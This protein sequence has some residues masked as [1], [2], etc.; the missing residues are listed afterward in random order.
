MSPAQLFCRTISAPT[1]IAGGSGT[2]SISCRIAG[3]AA[4]SRIAAV[5]GRII[6]AGA[7][8]R[9]GA[10]AGNVLSCAAGSRSRAITCRISAGSAARGPGRLPAT[11][12][13]RRRTQ[14]LWRSPAGRSAQLQLE[15][16]GDIAGR[17]CPGGPLCRGPGR[18]P[19]SLGPGGALCWFC[20]FSPR[21][22]SPPPQQ[23][24][25]GKT[26]AF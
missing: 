16:Q 22:P 10:A 24:E 6:A 25:A 12:R 8:S 21:G 3:A 9:T 17:P 23:L 18:P 19:I 2:R 26:D 11:C 13:A 7:S 15:D 20:E 4:G 14:D 5:G 1:W